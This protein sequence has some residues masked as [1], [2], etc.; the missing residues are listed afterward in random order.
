[1]YNSLI[2]LILGHENLFLLSKISLWSFLT[3]MWEWKFSRFKKIGKIIEKINIL[4]IL[5]VFPLIFLT[6]KNFRTGFFYYVQII[7]PHH[8][9][10]RHQ[11]EKKNVFVKTMVGPSYP[12]CFVPGYS[13][14]TCY[15]THVTSHFDSCHLNDSNF[16]FVHLLVVLFQTKYTMTDIVINLFSRNSRDFYEKAQSIWKNLSQSLILNYPVFNFFQ[17]TIKQ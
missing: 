16:T 4:T 9:E 8:A 1:M 6:K 13:S 14:F 17:K 12:T 5:H 11:I 15:L 7:W 2:V 10:K 3:P